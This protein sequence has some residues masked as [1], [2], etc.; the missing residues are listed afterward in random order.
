MVQQTL[1]DIFSGYKQKGG[2]VFKDRNALSHDYV[3][4]DTKHRD[5]QINS[6]GSVVAP[7]LQSA[8][9]SNV[10]VYGKTGTGK[11]LITRHVTNEL[12]KT[13]EGKVGV[14]DI[15]VR[16]FTPPVRLT[17]IPISKFSSVR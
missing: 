3:P 13:S 1:G 17:L 7:A 11:T 14:G 12:E 8:R 16:R 2:G 6:L 4:D 9:I 15:H 10:F 5:E